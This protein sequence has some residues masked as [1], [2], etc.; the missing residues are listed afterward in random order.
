MHA[1]LVAHGSRDPRFAATA[2][3]VRDAVQLA[4]PT[5]HVELAYLDLDV[6]SVPDVL[7]RLDG[8]IAVVPLLLGDAFHNRS[9]CLRSSPRRRVRVCAPHMRRCSPTPA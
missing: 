4:D 6:P 3:Q 1:V 5:V 8:D 2:R 7:A 9:T